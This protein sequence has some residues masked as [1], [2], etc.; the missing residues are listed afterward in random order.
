M[1][2][3]DP[4]M[5]DEDVKKGTPWGDVLRSELQDS[6]IGIIFVTKQ[7]LRADWLAF[8]AGA[9][10]TKLDSGFVCPFLFN[11]RS[12]D[13]KGPL[14]QFQSTMFSRDDIRRLLDTLNTA[15][16]ELDRLREGILES[17]FLRCYPLLERLLEQIATP[18]ET[19][20]DRTKPADQ[21][22][23]PVDS[24]V[25][26]SAS[27][28]AMRL[29]ELQELLNSVKNKYIILYLAVNLFRHDLPWIYDS[30]LHFLRAVQA[31]SNQ[32]QIANVANAFME[33]VE[34]TFE[35]PTITRRYNT[36][37]EGHII[38]K[39]RQIVYA[40]LNRST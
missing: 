30:G 40:V 7:N 33:L 39:L 15:A 35:N 17:A 10:S 9:L 8:E 32:K 11:V 19:L 1:E 23:S 6:R 4:F 29:N 25:I 3:V 34:A 22:A 27:D 38:G 26:V 2:F 37:Q 18:P 5:S 20:P 14:G 36:Q 28:R 31:P 12:S 16:S 24:S 13:V 21:E